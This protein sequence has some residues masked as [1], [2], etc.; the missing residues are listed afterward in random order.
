MRLSTPRGFSNNLK[1]TDES[2]QQQTG[3]ACIAHHPA[4]LPNRPSFAQAFLGPVLAGM[5]AGTASSLVR[6]PTEVIKQRLQT[7]EFVGAVTAVG[8]RPG[9]GSGRQ[10]VRACLQG[11]Q[12]ACTAIMHIYIYRFVNFFPTRQHPLRDLPRC[13]PSLRGRACAGSMRATGP[14]CCATCPLMPLSLWHMSR[15]G[16]AIWLAQW[17]FNSLPKS[18][19]RAGR[20]ASP[21]V[22]MDHKRQT[23]TCMATSSMSEHRAISSVAASSCAA[24][25][26]APTSFHAQQA[27][28]FQHLMLHAPA[29]PLPT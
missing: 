2:A 25:R 24:W 8:G 18:C 27:C 19:A 3:H 14:S 28:P 9:M 1:T 6:V 10:R 4:H 23:I 5:A 12:K 20:A 29:D 15:W 7:K 26:D 21:C 16:R 17:R 22:R 13:A 11:C